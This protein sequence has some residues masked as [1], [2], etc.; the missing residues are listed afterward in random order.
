MEGN[1]IVFQK[2]E[3]LTYLSPEEEPS[4]KN[5]FIPE[6]FEYLKGD[7]YNGFT[8]IN[9]SDG[10]EFVWIP[11][12]ALESDGTLDGVN[13]TEQFGRR[14]WE[15]KDVISDLHEKVD[16]EFIQSIKEHGGFYFS[17]YEASKKDGKIVFKGDQCPYS[18]VHY[19]YARFD[20]CPD[21]A[22]ENPGI[23]SILPYGA[24][25]DTVF[26][27][28]VQFGYKTYEEV[29]VDSTSWGC[30]RNNPHINYCRVNT[31]YS[32]EFCV[33]NIYDL[34]GNH[35]EWSQES[36]KGRVVQ[37]G[38]DRDCRGDSFPAAGRRW[39]DAYSV[40][41]RIYQSATTF[42]CVLY[43]NIY[44]VQTVISQF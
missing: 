30:Y 32:E 1:K 21:Y 19:H 5:P 8:I 6:G 37:R 33:C 16:P 43:A 36:F 14:P 31:G 38:G 17:A 41:G 28:I 23:S 25:Y 40:S 13:F 27:W 7:W 15:D 10:S 3:W 20:Y 11:V 26:K 4:Y 35:D 2:E 22:K 24:V 42:R 34:A 39:V 9:K 18:G 29:A 12:G 44:N